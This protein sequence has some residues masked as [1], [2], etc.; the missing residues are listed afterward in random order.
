MKISVIVPLYNAEKT[1]ARC[2]DSL[3]A[4]TFTDFELLLVNDGSCDH[5]AEIIAPYT[6]K[7]AFISMHNKENGGVS[8]ARNAGISMA[9]GELLTFVD[10]DDEVSPTFL[11]TFVNGIQGH[12][13]C[14]QSMTLVNCQGERT[15]V[16][17]KERTLT[18][19]NDMA[20]SVLEALQHDLPVSS[21]SSV[22][23]AKLIH[24]HNLRFDERMPV[25]EDTDF[26]LRYLRRCT[27]IQISAKPDYI[28]YTPE[29]GKIYTEENE[30][31]MCL[32]LLDDAYQLTTNEELRKRFRKYYLDPAIEA[33]FYYKGH[34]HLFRLATRFGRLCQPYLHESKRPSFRHR[35]FK[36]VCVFRHPHAIIGTSKLVMTLYRL[37]HLMSMRWIFRK[38]C[39]TTNEERNTSVRHG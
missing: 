38:P 30:L 16:C 29:I 14:M 19:K 35:L 25:C 18:E 33:L 15:Q 17:L 13:F 3:I 4:Q 7:H 8:S 9:R 22:F 32:Q 36:R 1:I 27:S 21:C 31:Q 34:D 28:Y 20:A 26:V 12:D 11:S 37:L 5:S 23:K 10:A 2:I 39:T 24:K 6:Q